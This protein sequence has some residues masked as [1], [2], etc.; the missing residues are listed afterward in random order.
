[1]RA[2]DLLSVAIDRRHCVLFVSAATDLDID[3]LVSGLE[4]DLLRLAHSQ[5]LITADLV[6]LLRASHFVVEAAT[7]P[8]QISISSDVHT[9]VT[10][11]LRSDDSLVADLIELFS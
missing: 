2:K 8:V 1:M 3:K 11:D 5:L 10:I 9:H 6:S 4:S 7:R